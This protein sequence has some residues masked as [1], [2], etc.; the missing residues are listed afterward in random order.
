MFWAPEN[1]TYKHTHTDIQER[2]H[3]G[4][5]PQLPHTKHEPHTML[6]VLIAE[7]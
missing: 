7:L 3:E 5:A 6:T 1:L 4:E 2:K